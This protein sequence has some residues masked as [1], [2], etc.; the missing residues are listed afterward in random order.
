MRNFSLKGCSSI[1]EYENVKKVGE[2]TFGEVNIMVHRTKGSKFA[3]KRILMHNEKEGIPITALREIKILKSLHHENIIELTEIA[4]KKGNLKT[5][6]RGEVHMVF[7]FMDHDL[8]GLLENPDIR[9]TPHQIKSYFHQLLCG[10]DYLHKNNIIHRDI[11]TANILIDNQGWL[12]IADFGLARAHIKSLPNPKYTNMVV[13]RWYR[14][15]ELLLGSTSYGCEIDMWGIGCVFGEILHRRPVL[16][17]NDDF[18]QLERIW[19]LCGTPTTDTTSLTSWPTLNELPGMSSIASFE[20]ARPRAIRT[21]FEGFV[22]DR[23]F[24]GAV[25]LID[26]LLVC[27]PARRLTA[28]K[29]L[30]HHYFYN[31]NFDCKWENSHE[32]DSRM[33]RQNQHAESLIPG[34]KEPPRRLPT[35]MTLPNDNENYTIINRRITA[36]MS[37][38]GAGGEGGGG[39]SR[40]PRGAQHRGG[41][42]HQPGGGGERTYRGGHGG[43]HGGRGGD[44]RPR[45]YNVPQNRNYGGGGGGAGRGDGYGGGGGG[46]NHYRGGDR[47]D[48]FRR[49]EGSKRYDGSRDYRDDRDRDRDRGRDT[50][51]DRDWDRDRE[52]GSSGGGGGSRSFGGSSQLPKHPLPPR[53]TKD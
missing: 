50:D 37:S 23:W 14:P 21:F 52:R 1:D 32:L 10:T 16:V 6:E 2:G 25:D 28:E 44:G 31:M 9:F 35:H 26:E 48:D 3:L 22:Q 41:G 4:V 53:P 49:E 24:I 46:G 34:T 20:P 42:G 39:G 30:Q 36:G 11:K 47:G 29:A 12:K 51:R 33:R 38:G 13:T 8:N 27:D 18:D 43:Q 45:P 7:P 15:P 19:R 40:G 5:R 17:G